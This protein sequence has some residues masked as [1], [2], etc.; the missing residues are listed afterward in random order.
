ML[1]LRVVKAI[2]SNMLVGCLGREI[3]ENDGNNQ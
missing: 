3:G 1:Y 2:E